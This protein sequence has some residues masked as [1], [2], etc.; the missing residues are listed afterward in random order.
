MGAMGP[1][2]SGGLAQE[3]LARVKEEVELRVE[4]A[5]NKLE[6]TRERM[7]VSEEL[8]ATRAESHRIYA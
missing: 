2:S 4:T 3:N 7:K 8:L 5:Y 1:S 6:R